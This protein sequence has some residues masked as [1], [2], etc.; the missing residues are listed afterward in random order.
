MIILE[1]TDKSGK[2]TFLNNLVNFFPEEKKNKL[3]IVH[4]G[5]LPDNWNYCDDYLRYIQSNTILDRFIDS[6]RAYGPV[7]RN[8]VNNKLTKENLNKVYRK[9]SEIGTLV[10]YCKPDIDETMKRI[11][12]QKDL[13]VKQID[14]LEKLRDQFDIIFDKKYPLN[15]EIIDTTHNIKNEIF[16]YIVNKSII[17]ENDSKNLMNLNYRGFTNI[18]AKYI[19]YVYENIVDDIIN[20]INDYMDIP[21]TNFCIILSRNIENKCVN[22]NNLYSFI[23]PKQVYVIGNNSLNDYIEANNKNHYIFNNS[24]YEFLK[25]KF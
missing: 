19:I 17:L 12:D 24:L 1:G 6:E 25:E 9:C 21:F 11:N 18:N 14:H 16:E 5:L 22:I 20:F 4:F 3:N 8:G 2:T 7:F 10:V 23:M 15:L 13:M